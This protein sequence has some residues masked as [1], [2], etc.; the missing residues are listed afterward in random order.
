MVKAT[1]KQLAGAYEK[2]KAA[3]L[4]HSRARSSAGRDIGE[5]P[6]LTANEKR[7]RKSISN[8]LK[9]FALKCFPKLFYLPF[10]KAHL[11]LLK[12]FED[13]I[14]KGEQKAIAMPRGSGKTTIAKIAVIWAI[15]T[16]KRF[17]CL[18]LACNGTAAR[19]ILESIK[20]LIEVNEELYRYFP[21]VCH[22]IRM[23]EGI[24]MRAKGQTYNGE[25]TKIQFAGSKFVFPTIPDS[26]SSGAVVKCCG[27]VGGGIRG[28]NHTTQSGEVIRPDIV[29]ADD[30]QTN[31]SA[32]SPLQCGKIHHNMEGQVK[33]LAG[34]SKTLAMIQTGTVIQ[35]DDYFD[36][37]L[38]NDN[39]PDWN[40][41]RVSML[42]PMPTNMELWGKYDLV[43]REGKRTKNKELANKFY[44]KYFKEMNKGAKVYWDHI[45]LPG[46]ISAIQH[47]MN[48]YYENEVSF[49]A[50]RQ[51]RPLAEEAGDSRL[52]QDEVLEKI[53]G[54][55]RFWIPER[56]NK[57]VMFIDVHKRVLFHSLCA[58]T[59]EFDGYVIDYGTYPEQPSMMFRQQDAKN[60]LSKIFPGMSEE[61]YVGRGLEMI[62]SMYFKKIFQRADG[63]EMM[64][65]LCMVDARYQGSSN[66]V[67]DFCAHPQRA[68]MMYPSQGEGVRASNTPYGERAKADGV[69]DG[70]NWKIK[71]A[72]KTRS[73]SPRVIFDTNFWKSFT[74][75]RI[76]TPSGVTGSMSIFG[77]NRHEHTAFSQHLTAE[78]PTVVAAGKRVIEEWQARPNTENHFFDCIVGCFVAASICG[79]TLPGVSEIMQESE[80][81]VAV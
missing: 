37:L 36:Q 4:A 78:K 79:A 15:L 23:L 17:Y 38:N 58:F 73:I 21:E 40:G 26:V 13:V 34:P 67:F 68:Q 72:T 33:G 42:D 75:N 53:N 27:I 7:T 57:L 12:D 8:S 71:T 39:N 14:I 69:V 52:T 65:N 5:I 19:E 28:I 41:K 16:G 22:P 10:S 1:K 76:K 43:R 51:N 6:R 44:K 49:W 46:E 32:A 25:L 31:E 3:S 30:L 54:Y 9:K 77:R 62:E 80:N 66:T 11:Q 45:T 29:F 20:T 81:N 63:L 24:A 55:D 47:A 35:Q 64:I 60:P 48:L 61:A 2:S 56:C 74:A 50:E 59:P 18:V 70:F